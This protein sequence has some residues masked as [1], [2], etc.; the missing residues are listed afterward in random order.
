MISQK[1]T[2]GELK[3]EEYT[4]SRKKFKELEIEKWSDK[5]IGCECLMFTV[6]ESCSCRLT[7]CKCCFEHCPMV[8]WR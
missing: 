1:E 5:A 8:Y 4:Q 7:D 2:E 6:T 3:K